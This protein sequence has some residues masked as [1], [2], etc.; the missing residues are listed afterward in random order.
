MSVVF[1][2]GAAV[3]IGR[4]IA[5]HFA[6][7][8]YVVVAHYNSSDKEASILESELKSYNK[9]SFII[10][11]DFQEESSYKNLIKNVYEVCGR[12]DVLIHNASIFE[13]DDI[14]TCNKDLFDRH[15]NINLWAPIFLTKEFIALKQKINQ[16]IV[17]I[18]D[19]RV[20]N[21]TQNFLSYTVTKTSLFTLTRTLAMHLAPLIRVNAIGPGPTYKNKFQGHMDFHE[22]TLRTLLK[23]PVDPIDICSAIDFLIENNSIT[24]QMIAIDGGQNIYRG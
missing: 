1:I 3:R 22:Q 7:K 16:N 11:A 18:L 9:E 23:K 14:N 17:M 20:L 8:R 5:I 4:D 19:Q 12:I 24:G 13:F 2:T 21:P 6:K 15:I 10:K